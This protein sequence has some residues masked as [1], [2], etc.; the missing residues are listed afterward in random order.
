MKDEALF[1]FSGLAAIAGGVLRAANAFTEGV[2]PG[3]LLP[4]LYFATDVF[5]I[6]G[7]VGLY[8]KARAPIGWAGLAGFVIAVTGLLM[9]RSGVL[10][11]GYQTGASVALLGTVLLGLTM[12]AT[13]QAIAAPVLW[14]ASLALGVAA[15]ASP[16]MTWASS[17]AG[18]MYGMGFAVAG[19]RLAGS[20]KP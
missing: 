13:R 17:L 19:W 12:L 5:L 20:L 11:G 6:F 14:A 7:L 15:M 10:F 9:V 8:L 4:Q 18:V 1:R 2:V 3:G 16:T